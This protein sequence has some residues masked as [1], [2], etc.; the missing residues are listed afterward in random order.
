MRT[1]KIFTVVGALA[2]LSGLGA[3]QALPSGSRI[4]IEGNM[5]HSA[6][7][8]GNAGRAKYSDGKI[9]FDEV[10]GFDLY[11]TAALQEKQVP[12]VVV[13]DRAKADYILGGTW[14][15]IKSLG[16]KSSVVANLEAPVFGHAVSDYDGASIRLV[17]LKTSEVVFAYSVD[18]NNAPHG[19]QSTAESVAKH[20]KAAMTSGPTETKSAK[21]TNGKNRHIYAWSISK[22]P[23]FNF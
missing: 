10:S 9:A 8:A 4:Y 21:R 19:R 11:L 3:A 5:G 14:E 6:S 7:L 23:A 20:L 13:T 18:R 22:D 16:R 1:M 2:L 15:H 12:L 17:D